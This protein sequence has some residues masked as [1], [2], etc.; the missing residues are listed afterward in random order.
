MEK[1][2]FKKKWESKDETCFMCGQVTKFNRGLTKQNLGKMFKKPTPQDWIIFII[3]CLSLLGFLQ[4]TS[5]VNYYE[6]LFENVPK[7][8]QKYQQGILDNFISNSNEINN[9]NLINYPTIK[10]IKDD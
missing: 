7:L 6:E 1:K 4:Y 3:L 10:I 5:E 2:T 9:T 8:C